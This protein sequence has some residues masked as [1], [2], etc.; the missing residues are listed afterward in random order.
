MSLTD[1]DR[2]LLSYY[3]SSEINGALFFGR[4]ART[5]RAGKLQA[6]V[7]HHFSDEA[8]HAAYWTDCINDLGASPDKLRESYQDQ[9]LQAIGMPANL[10]EVMAITQVFE[11][12]VIGQYRQH[13][14][15][16][17]L[18]PRIRHTIETIMVDERWHVQYVR[19]ALAGME[20]RYGTDRVA[21]T[22]ARFTEADEEIYAKTLAEYDERIRH[23]RVAEAR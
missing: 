1:N 15:A 2:W 19:D 4:I 12:R 18:H 8:S 9:Y 23:L 21:A 14:R 17:G 7:T 20:S 5:V 6:Q 22:I 13:L 16:P 11:K 10:M 3:R